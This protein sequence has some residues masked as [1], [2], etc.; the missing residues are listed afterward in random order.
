MCPAPNTPVSLHFMFSVFHAHASWNCLPAQGN[1]F[2]FLGIS[3][4][5]SHATTPPRHGHAAATRI[6][7]GSPVRLVMPACHRGGGL[8]AQEVILDKPGHAAGWGAGDA[9]E[10]H[11]QRRDSQPRRR[12]MPACPFLTTEIMPGGSQEV[13][14]LSPW[15]AQPSD[16]S[17]DKVASS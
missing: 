9:A 14:P 15:V 1:I 5:L 3:L 6:R 2:R 17:G 7:P 16:I 12:S 4:Q 10:L 11:G 13:L 8:P